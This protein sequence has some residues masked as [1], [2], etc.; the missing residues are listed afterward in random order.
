MKFVDVNPYFY[1]FKGGIERR[2]HDTASLLAARGHDETI[3]TGRLPD[4][5]EEERTP[6]GYRIMRLE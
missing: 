6:E 2:M 1:P 5:P 3:H 4:T